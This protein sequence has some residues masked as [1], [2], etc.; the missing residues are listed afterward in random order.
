MTL[1]AIFPGIE[2]H[3]QDVEICPPR[4]RASK[5]EQFRTQWWRLYMS[6][7]QAIIVLVISLD[8][9]LREAILLFISILTPH[10]I[11][12][13]RYPSTGKLKDSRSCSSFGCVAVCCCSSARYV[14]FCIEFPDAPIAGHFVQQKLIKTSW[15]FTFLCSTGGFLSEY[16]TMIV[17]GNVNKIR[18]IIL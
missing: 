6:T 4:F 16:A 13:R 18:K 9:T 1:N 8:F 15:I 2:C 3:T 17:V 7:Q 5:I 11:V 14:P 12:R 10:P